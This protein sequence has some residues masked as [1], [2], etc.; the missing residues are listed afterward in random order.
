[1]NWFRNLNATPRLLLSFGVLIAFIA[2]ISSVAIIN[3][4][5]GN[6]RLKALYQSDMQGAIQSANIT[7]ARMSLGRQGRDALIHI[8]DP[9]VFASDHKS[10]LSDF[11]IIHANLDAAD[12]TF[13]SGDGKELM[14]TIRNALPAYEK[15]YHDL[16]DRIEAKDLAGA[17]I[18]LAAI[19]VVGQPLYDAC[20]RARVLKETKG[21]EKF[22]TNDLAFQSTRTVMLLM[23]AISIVLGMLLAIFIARGF[24]GPLREAAAALDLMAAGDLTASVRIDSRDEMGRMAASLNTA[25]ERLR[26]TLREVTESAERSNA[27]SRELATTAHEIAGGAQTQASSLEETSASLEQITATVQQN[28]DNARQANQ[29]ATGSR[30]SAEQGQGVVSQAIAAMADI[31]TASGKISDIISTINEIAFQTNLLAVNAAVEA[32]RAGEEGRG[33]AVVA[34]EVRSLAQRSAGASR[35]IA[36]LIQDS[37]DKVKAG[38]ELVNRSGAT[39]QGIVGSVKRVTDI[40]GEMAAAASEQSTG[41]N[42]VNTAITQ[43]D[44]VTQSNSAKTEQLAESAQSFS[45]QAQ[46]LLQLVGQFKL[47]GDGPSGRDQGRSSMA[48]RE[49]NGAK[50]HVAKP[51]ARPGGAKPGSSMAVVSKQ[52]NGPVARISNAVALSH[53]DGFE[54]F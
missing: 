42:Q 30:E 37:S 10:M 24:A 11:V 15:A 23:A 4:G 28:A 12:S 38:A 16:Y 39:L 41:V 27:S 3:L 33:F 31:S 13:Y 5:A 53:D 20:D 50:R 32:A 18:A 45:E 22:Q 43:M 8:G 19:T 17:K 47:G 35:E 26:S 1:M 6:D 46:L 36:S 52:A 25:L 48:S 7:V 54:E 49:A 2:G 29:L 14:A 9:V 21:K 34:A 51:I 40:V 44:R